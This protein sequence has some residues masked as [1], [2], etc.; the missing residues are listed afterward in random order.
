MQKDQSFEKSYGNIHLV[1]EREGGLK[2]CWNKMLMY[3]Q[4]YYIEAT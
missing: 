3:L 1:T 2:N 4:N